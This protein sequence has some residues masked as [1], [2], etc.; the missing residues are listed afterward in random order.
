MSRY[1]A[2]KKRAYLYWIIIVGI[3]LVVVNAFVISFL[4]IKPFISF[5]LLVFY[6]IPSMGLILLLDKYWNFTKGDIGESK[7]AKALTKIPGAGI[8]NDIILPNAKWNID[9][10]VVTSGGIFVI[11]TKNYEGKM[12]ANGDY[13]YQTTYG[14]RKKVDSFTKQAKSGAIQLR[15]YLLELVKHPDKDKLFVKPI[16]VLIGK[17]ERK[18]IVTT[19]DVV[20]LR[21]LVGLI[22]SSKVELDSNLIS[23][24][25]GVLKA[26]VN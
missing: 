17:F 4:Q 1:S 25:N 15:N 12:E 9:H 26:L 8:Y 11:E 3:S 18:D 20:D 19:D 21:E 22:E 14:K 23:E 7:V 10:V 2:I 16:V 5:I 6:S 24:T 13:W